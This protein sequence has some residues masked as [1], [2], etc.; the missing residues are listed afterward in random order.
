MLFN[1]EDFSFWFSVLEKK[2][3]F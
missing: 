1:I 2:I 3:F